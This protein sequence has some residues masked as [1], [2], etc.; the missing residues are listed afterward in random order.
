MPLKNYQYQLILKEYDQKRL[1]SHNALEQRRQKVYAQIPELSELDRQMREDSIRSAKA[2][3]FGHPEE[4]KQ[5]K[6]RNEI[7]SKRKIA[8][9]VKYGYPSDYLEPHYFCEDC[10]DTGYIGTEKCHCFKQAVVDLIYAQSNVKQAIM[11]ENFKTFSFSY[12]NDDTPDPVTGLTPL[13][14]IKDVMEKVDNFITNFQTSDENLLFYGNTGVGKTFLS[15]CIA[16]ELLSRGYTVIYLTAFELFH[17]LE[18]YTFDKNSENQESYENQFDNILDCDLL[19]IDDLGTELNNSFTSSQFYL[20][21]NERYLKRKST[22]ISSNLFLEEIGSVY[23]E[24][25][26]SRLTSNY[27]L[28]RI[29]GEDI[30]ILKQLPNQ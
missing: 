15:H 26:F 1:Q 24:R 8:C 19:I 12:Y 22:I 14:N 30:R 3:L 10:Q 5:L 11:L 13:A 7:L 25:I 17:T 2:S 9:L 6:Q 23:S 29:F 4:L 27:I 18:H 28:L 21:I 16:G 20:C